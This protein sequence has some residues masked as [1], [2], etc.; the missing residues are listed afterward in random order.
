MLRTRPVHVR[1]LAL[2]AEWG[3][4]T[5]EMYGAA[6]SASSQIRS[7]Y[8]S[9]CLSNVPALGQPGAAGGTLQ[10]PQFDTLIEKIIAYHKMHA[11]VLL[12]L[13]EAVMYGKCLLHGYC[14]CHA[15]GTLLSFLSP[16]SSSLSSEHSNRL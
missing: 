3:D 13:Y 15:T 8:A 9:L 16:R 4:F 10:P 7:T 6:S 14:C 11:Y 2:A 1:V 5:S 12:V